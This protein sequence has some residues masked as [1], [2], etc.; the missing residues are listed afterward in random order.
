MLPVVM[1]KVFVSYRHVSP[2]EGLAQEIEALLSS[3]DF[4]VF[5]DTKIEVGLRWVEEI[6]R[7]LLSSQFFVVL[8]SKDSIRSDMV[9]REIQMAHR[10][11]CDGQIRILP[12]RL[13]F[14][15]ELPYDLGAYLDPLQYVRWEDATPFEPICQRLLRAIQHHEALPEPARGEREDLDDTT[16][17]EALTEATEKRG[18]PLPV[19]DPRLETGTLN[20]SSPWYVKRPE[21]EEIE[22]FVQQEG[23]TAVIKAPRQFGKSSLMAR[24]RSLARDS[25][26]RTC[27]LDFQLIDDEHLED[28]G[29]LCRY[30]A[31]KMARSFRTRVQPEEVWDDF[32]GPKDSLTEF[33]A[34]AVLEAGEEQVLLCLDEADRVFDRPY[35][36][37]FFLGVRGWHNMRATH[38]LWNRLNLV[39]VHSTDPALWI[40]NLNVSPFNVGLRLRLE[41]FDRDHLIDLNQRHGN[42][43]QDRAEIERLRHLIGGQP[44][45]CRQAFF[46]LATD[47]ASLA[48]LEQGAEDDKGPFG[49]H[50]RQHL[51]RLR[52]QECGIQ[53]LRQVLHEGRCAEDRDFERLQA[54]GLVRGSSRQSVAPACELYERYFRRHL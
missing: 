27:I 36:D 47:G 6:E 30:L 42:P 46:V 19:A 16:D 41:A 48:D 34:A 44:Y 25:G 23:E 13:A 24:A 45:L 8:L 18:A 20:P 4:E 2:D 17:F 10:L 49:D 50:M 11:E 26:H 22:S 51:A 3:H 1:A 32:L 7:R 54:A 33:L 40:E 12:V 52:K 31:H 43:L 28:L 21:D 29:S 35:R 37:D 14:D 38:P 53:A 15:G 39:I 5:L 9:R